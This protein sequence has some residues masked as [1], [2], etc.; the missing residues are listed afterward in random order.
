MFCLFVFFFRFSFR[1]CL[2]CDYLMCFIFLDLPQ[3]KLMRS[4]NSYPLLQFVLQKH[5]NPGVLPVYRPIGP[6]LQIFGLITLPLV[7]NYA[8]LGWTKK[9]KSSKCW[10]GRCELVMGAKIRKCGNESQPC[11]WNLKWFHKS[12]SAQRRRWYQ[13]FGIQS[14][15]WFWS[16]R[17]HCSNGSV[18]LWHP[19]LDDQ[20]QTHDQWFQDWVYA[21][22]NEGAATEH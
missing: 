5:E 13:W 16:R 6:G 20:W 9:L 2:N 10:W 14:K 17:R 18:P 7:I 4:L 3:F 22:W 19:E 21:H 11:R 8:L 1:T 12:N 15:R